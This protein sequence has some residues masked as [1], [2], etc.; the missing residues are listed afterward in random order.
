MG[1]GGDEG[2]GGG[3]E[4]DDFGGGGGGPPAGAEAKRSADS[5]RR[6]RGILKPRVELSRHRCRRVPSWDPLEKQ[7]SHPARRRGR[8]PGSHNG[9]GTADRWKQTWSARQWRR[10]NVRLALRRR[11]AQGNSM[12]FCLF[13]FLLPSDLFFSGIFW[14]GGGGTEQLLLQGEAG[15][16][17]KSG[18]PYEETGGNLIVCWSL[19]ARY[20]YMLRHC[21]KFSS[22]W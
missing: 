10:R 7:E 9:I 20:S 17:E 8:Q 21:L 13:R 12:S 11:R 3:G 15:L 14:M 5:R 18:Q 6:T 1:G 19:T 2:G 4:V 16:S 22:V